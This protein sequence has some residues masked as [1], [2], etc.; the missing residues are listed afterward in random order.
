MLEGIVWFFTNLGLAI[1]NLLYAVTHPGSWLGWLGGLETPEAKE[2]LMRFIFY[3]G[4]AEFFFALLL[5]VLVVTL[6]GI[7]HRPFLWGCVRGLEAI[8]NT[9]GRVAA[10]AGLIMVLQQIVSVYIQRIFARADLAFGFGSPFV[11]DVS[12][13]SEELKLYN[14]IIVCLACA[15]T[16]VQGGHVRVDLVYAAVGYRAKKIIDMLGSVLFM[17]PMAVLIWMYAWYFMWRHLINPPVSA[18]GIWVVSLWYLPLVSIPSMI[19]RR[20]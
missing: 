18:C 14:A 8:G 5:V 4:S 3:G 11:K 17:M 13:W 12:W 1:Y 2:S 6:A 9:V 7:V 20:D 10:C 16:F 19:P 15:Y